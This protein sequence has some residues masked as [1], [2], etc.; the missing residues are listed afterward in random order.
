MTIHADMAEL[1]PGATRSAGRTVAFTHQDYGE[2]FGRG[3]RCSI[4]L[5]WS[6]ARGSPGRVGCGPYDGVVPPLR[7]RLAGLLARLQPPRGPLLG[8]SRGRP[9]RNGNGVPRRNLKHHRSVAIK[10]APSELATSL[11]V[12][13]FLRE[14]GIAGRADPPA[15]PRAVRFRPGRRPALL[16]DAL[17]RG[18]DAAWPSGARGAVVDTDGSASR[19]RSPMPSDTPTRG[20]VHRDIKPE[21][22]MFS[23]AVPSWPTSGSPAR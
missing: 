4:C 11:G 12:E 7:A 18:R 8:R 13:R 5:R 6:E 2:V 14:I 9:R 15:H 16:R 17:H 1:C 3:G 23:A 21:N 10:V 19:A 22:I 20:V